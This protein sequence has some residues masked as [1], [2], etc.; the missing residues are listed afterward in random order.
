MT[1]ASSSAKR[2]GRAARRQGSGRRLPPGCRRRS[3][4]LTGRSRNARETSR[5]HQ[6]H[7]RRPGLV[8]H[9]IDVLVIGA[10]DRNDVFDAADRA[11]ER[12]GSIAEVNATVVSRKAWQDGSSPFLEQVQRGTLVPL[13]LDTAQPRAGDE[14]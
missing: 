4:R 9:D 10:A 14:A 6:R 1:T 7:E 3:G 8:P 5:R 12:L 13:A 11:R 2:P